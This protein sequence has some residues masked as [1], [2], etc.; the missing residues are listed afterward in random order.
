MPFA[1]MITA[2]TLPHAVCSSHHTNTNTF[3]I[4]IS[5]YDWAI[6]LLVGP[7]ILLGNT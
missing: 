2:Y 6:F 5:M 7:Q 4:G 1:A 3:S